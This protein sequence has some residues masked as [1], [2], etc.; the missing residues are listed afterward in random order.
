M[1]VENARSPLNRGGRAAQLTT[2]CERYVSRNQPPSGCRRNSSRSIQACAAVIAAVHLRYREI[3]TPRKNVAFASETA[4]DRRLNWSEEAAH[5][6][7]DPP[8]PL[9]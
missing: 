7:I 3:S 4:H 1:A 5:A 9:S 6:P 2:S 8:A